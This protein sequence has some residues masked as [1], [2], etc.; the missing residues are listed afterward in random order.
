MTDD[1]SG[2]ASLLV[3]EGAGSVLV[4]SGATPG[5][6]SVPRGSVSVAGASSGIVVVG[7]CVVGIA[8]SGVGEEDDEDGAVPSGVPRCDVGERL[9]R[10]GSGRD[11]GR[12][13]AVVT[14]AVGRGRGGA[15]DD[16]DVVG[17]GAGGTVGRGRGVVGRG[18]EVGG[19]G[20]DWVGV[21][22]GLGGLGVLVGRV[23]VGVGV[24]VSPGGMVIVGCG[25]ITRATGTDPARGWRLVAAPVEAAAGSTVPAATTAPRPTADRATSP[26]PGAGRNGW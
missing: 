19:A 21:L 2:S 5:A 6:A 3:G 26:R 7:C 25:L 1:A 23:R 11:V 22:V 10:V 9:E 12:G 13:G 15:G 24:G 17:P 14:V 18:D 16:G 8:S 20:G 4:G